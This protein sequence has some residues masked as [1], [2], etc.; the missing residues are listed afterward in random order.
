ML[1]PEIVVFVAPAAHDVHIVNHL[2]RVRL[3]HAS[4][5]S[6]LWKLGVDEKWSDLSVSDV[7]MEGKS[8]QWRHLVA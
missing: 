3:E 6:Q 8:W 5:A 1:I 4:R 7:M 2:S